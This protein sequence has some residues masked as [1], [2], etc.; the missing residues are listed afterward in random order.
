MCAATAAD[1]PESLSVIG[2]DD[3]HVDLTLRLY[4]GGRWEILKTP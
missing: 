2:G 3:A 1:Y 4:G